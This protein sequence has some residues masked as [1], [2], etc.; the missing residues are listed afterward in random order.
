MHVNSV[1][2]QK[3]A[4]LSASKRKLFGLCHAIRWMFLAFALW[5]TVN[6]FQYWSDAPK[7]LSNMGRFL[8][9]D[10]SDTP[11]Y[12]VDTILGIYLIEH[13]F[14]FAAAYCV[15]RMTAAFMQEGLLTSSAPSWLVRCGVY[16]GV[17]VVLPLFT[18][19][20][21]T[22]LFTLHLPE[23]QHVVKWWLNSQTL[24]NLI[25]CLSVIAFGLMFAWAVE[26]AEEN[27]GF[28]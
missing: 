27:R 3:S 25:F 6:T 26:V 19:P 20:L 18:F 22:Y 9:L 11:H 14:V 12:W 17:S 24:L 28:I 10:L 15:W 4:S 21:S 7:V 16:G 1:L 8:Q 5:G 2:L 23:A 13:L